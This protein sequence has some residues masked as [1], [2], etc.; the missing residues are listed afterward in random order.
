MKKSSVRF[1]QKPWKKISNWYF[2]I[3]KIVWLLLETFQCS[4]FFNERVAASKKEIKKKRLPMKSI[5][6]EKMCFFRKIRITST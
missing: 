6:E 1:V 2:F 4:M 5:K 3:W